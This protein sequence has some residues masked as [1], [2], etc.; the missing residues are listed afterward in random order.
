MPAQGGASLAPWVASWASILYAFILVWLPSPLGAA[1]SVV[2]FN[3]IHYHPL[4]ENNDTEWIELRSLMGVNVDMSGWKLEGGVNY[5]FAEDTVIPGH[6]YLLIAADPNHHTLTGKRALG[7]FT[8]RLA[9]NGETV[10]LVNN[11]DRTMDLVS[12]GDDG[13][14]PV[15]ADGLGATLSKRT[16]NTAESRPFNWVASSEFGGTP[17]SSNFPLEDQ[18]PTVSSILTLSSAW[19]Y[20]E[21]DTS[22]ALNWKSPSFD[23]DAWTSGDSVFFAGTMEPRGAGEG[24]LGYW[25][26]D[27]GT[28]NTA[29][30]ISE[31]SNEASLSGAS[32]GS[33]ETRSSFLTFAGNVGSFGNTGATTIPVMTLAR[34]FT[35]S[36]WARRAPGDTE[37]NSIILGNRF[38]PNGLDFSPRQFIK[39]TPS[40]LEWHMNG[41]GNNNLEYPD[42]PPGQ[43]Q[44]HAL[45]KAG[46]T[47][48]Y[49]RN[50]TQ[51]STGSISNGL[52]Q[53]Q[54]LYF[55]GE[56]S[57]GGGEFFNGSLDDPAIWE[58]AL[59]SSSI[60]GLAGGTLTPLTA[61]TIDGGGGG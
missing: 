12:Y 37:Q 18:P 31:S 32:W 41:Q 45:V 52:D 13:D 17:G 2:V 35:W 53:P 36:F 60:A 25:P 40:R 56:T 57:G 6:G 8:G 22:P 19:K 15:G 21:T 11:S 1:D 4:N 5:T 44:H 54:P 42:L 43:W 39:F 14:W 7:P 59:P 61:P 38:A 27:E 58:K 48:T 55:G 51:A 46:S 33:D 10:R 23:D 24:L 47:L 34:D 30:D 29:S 16:Q 20:R 49:F 3:E 28:G 26:L 50:G 9:N